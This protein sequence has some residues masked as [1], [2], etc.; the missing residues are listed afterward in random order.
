M[1]GRA[2]PRPPVVQLRALA[3]ESALAMNPPAL[4]SPQPPEG[5][6][7]VCGAV[8]TRPMGTWPAPRCARSSRVPGGFISRHL[9]QNLEVVDGIPLYS[10]ES[11]T[12]KG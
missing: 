7:P 5:F 10:E 4:R 11:E 8:G 1:V 12:Q 9:P 3:P 2:G 6:L